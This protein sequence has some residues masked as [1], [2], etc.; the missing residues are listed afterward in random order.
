MDFRIKLLPVKWNYDGRGERFET[1]Y[2]QGQFNHMD[3]QENEELRSNDKC[4][5]LS[6]IIKIWKES[7]NSDGQQNE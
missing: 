2:F 1:K 3:K 7:L 4:S 6:T 5:K